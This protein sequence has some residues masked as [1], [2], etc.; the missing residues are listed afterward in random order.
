MRGETF[1]GQSTNGKYFEV[2]F[3]LNK[4]AVIHGL[5]SLIAGMENGDVT[6]LKASHTT[7]NTPED[8]ETQTVMLTFNEMEREINELD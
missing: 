8:Y 1:N 2:G 3:G 5:R 4:E 6:L 7:S